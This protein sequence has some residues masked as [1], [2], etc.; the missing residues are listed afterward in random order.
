M[1][2]DANL[3][4]MRRLRNTPAIFTDLANATGNELQRQ[5][6]LRSQYDDEVVRA[7]LSLSE[8]RER[9]S[10]KFSRADRMWF[11][12]VGLEQATPEEVARHKAQRFDGP[13]WDLCCG[14]GGDSIALAERNDV[15]AVD[16]NP[17]ACLRTEWNADVYGVAD[18]ITTRTADVNEI[19]EDAV[20]SG[21]WIHVDPD[22]RVGRKR[23]L[24]IEDGQPDLDALIDL[25]HHGR[26]GAVK[27]SPASNFV[28]KFP[29]A[30]IEL[31]SLHGECKE[32]TVWFG[33]LGE[34]SLW[35]ATALPSGESICGDPLDAWAE[36]NSLG[37]YLF[38]PDPAVVRA[39]LVSLLAEQLEISRLDDADEYL[40]A[41]RQVSSPF[42]RTYRVVAEL[43]NNDR[44]LRKF[45]REANY[46][47]VEIKCRHVPVQAD[48]VRRK[49]PLGDGPMA[50][51]IYAKI[52]GRTKIVIAQ[53]ID[54]AETTSTA[55]TS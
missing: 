54:P 28:G 46:G 8:L 32:A 1:S 2:D 25:I 21:D 4:V 7:A 51:L 24:R 34:P 55:S 10:R 6:Q 40:T 42:L 17:A 45:V 35:R 13:V 15:N 20:A 49:L 5:K 12:R 16:L 48:A 22:R 3:E 47:Q 44:T 50:S 11:D 18:R 30:E 31:I 19:W 27:L 33:E 43:P 37:E 26:G 41:D 39:G 38:D 23:S 14:I 52:A 29:T 36:L 9:G 53:R